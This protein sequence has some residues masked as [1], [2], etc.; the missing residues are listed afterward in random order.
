VRYASLIA[1]I[2]VAVSGCADEEAARQAAARAEFEEAL[3][4][5][6]EADRGFV[7]SKTAEAETRLSEFRV[8]KLNEVTKRLEGVIANG[9]ASQRMAARQLLA[10]AITS[11]ARFISRQGSTAWADLSDRGAGLLSDLVAVGRTS[12]LAGSLDTDNTELVRKLEDDKLKTRSRIDTLGGE[13]E[14]LDGRIDELKSQ[15]DALTE[16]SNEAMTEARRLEDKAFPLKGDRRYELYDQAAVSQRKGEK[17]KAEADSLAVM[18]DVYTSE[19]SIIDRQ[20]NL[21]RQSLESIEAQIVQSNQRQ[22]DT[23]ADAE[24]ARQ[25]RDEAIE[26]LDQAMQQ[27]AADHDGSVEAVFDRARRRI[28]EALDV[29]QEVADKDKAAPTFDPNAVRADRLGKL[30]AK[31][32]IITSHVLAEASLGSTLA[33]IAARASADSAPLM[34]TKSQGFQSSVY[35]LAVRQAELIRQAMDVVQEATAIVDELETG[36]ESLAA[37]AQQYR[38]QLSKYPARLDNARI[39]PAEV[40]EPEMSEPEMSEPEEPEPVDEPEAEPIEEP[41]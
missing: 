9:S 38:D 34:P 18:W 1:V 6:G 27:I 29:L 2:L 3:T 19:R 26:K 31:L 28:D 10:E 13:Q 14:Q 35:Q 41:E 15:I 37:L 32:H 33:V 8:Q 17:T 5:F 30:M 23:D 39:L 22:E 4:L 12:A 40:T 16:K 25:K 7:D 21:A 36:G 24:Q 11:E 20:I